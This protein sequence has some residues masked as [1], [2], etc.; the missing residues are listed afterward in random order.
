MPIYVKIQGIDGDSTNSQFT[1]WFEISS[2]SWGD[3]N[4]TQG[5]GTGSGGGAG[6]VRFED[7][8]ISKPTG[9]G[10]PLLMVACA[11]GKHLPA[12]QLVVTQASLG[13]TDKQQ[14]FLQITLK[15]VLVSSYHQS[16]DSAGSPQDE[17]SLNFTD[18]E[19]DQTISAADGSI[20][21][22]SATWNLN[23]GN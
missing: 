1:N 10:S 4:S 6:K 8:T 5:H 17:M 9:K 12:V 13:S 20:T 14:V 15:D 21:V 2:F 11:S 23:G 19:Y 16:G 22:Q 3:S 18:I 7:L